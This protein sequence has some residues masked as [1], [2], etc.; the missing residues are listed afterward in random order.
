M[1]MPVT[2]AHE[3][4]AKH[5]ARYFIEKTCFV[6]KV[7]FSDFH[8]NYFSVILKSGP[9]VKQDK[10]FKKKTAHIVNNNMFSL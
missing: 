3:V 7:C 1:H 10:R 8:I 4:S 9:W 2:H 6:F 5:L